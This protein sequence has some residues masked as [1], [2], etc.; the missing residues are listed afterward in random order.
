MI[1]FEVKLN[2]RRIC[3]AGA[4]DLCVLSATIN[5]A[6]KLGV[7][8]VPSRR[9]NG[10]A[11]EV[12]YSVGGLTRR[13]DPTKDVHL[14]WKSVAPLRIGDRLV[15]KVLEVRKA[16]RPKSRKKAERRRK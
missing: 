13:P 7:K 9:N 12:F 4:E 1:A 5:A 16:D 8:T 15:I 11:R 2:G 10:S 3:I 6:G 14:R